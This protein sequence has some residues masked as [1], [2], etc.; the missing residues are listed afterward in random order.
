[1]IFSFVSFHST[2]SH[3]R[4]HHIMSHFLPL[5]YV[6]FHLISSHSLSYLFLHPTFGFQMVQA[7]QA[8]F[9]DATSAK[10]PQDALIDDF[11][12]ESSFNA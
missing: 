2:I 9:P 10:G 11:R 1:M 3:I 4:I 8:M 5:H 12:L 7:R 6:S